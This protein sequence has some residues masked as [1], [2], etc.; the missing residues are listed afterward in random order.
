MTGRDAAPSRGN[1]D[2]IDDNAMAT[3]G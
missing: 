3:L 1:E 2:G